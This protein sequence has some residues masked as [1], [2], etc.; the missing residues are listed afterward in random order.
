MKD[1]LLN[2]GADGEPCPEADDAIAPEALG[3]R[4]ASQAANEMSVLIKLARQRLPVIPIMT[5]LP[6]R[7]RLR[8]RHARADAR[9]CPSSSRKPDGGLE[10]PGKVAQERLGHSTNSVAAVSTSFRRPFPKKFSK[11]FLDCLHMYAMDRYGNLFQSAELANAALTQAATAVNQAA[12]AMAKYNHSS[13]NAGRD[14]MCAG[15]IGIQNGQLVWIDHNSGHNKPTRQNLVEPLRL[16]RDG[17]VDLSQA[18]VAAYT[19]TGQ[20]KIEIFTAQQFLANPD[21][22]PDV[23]TW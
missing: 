7:A 13:F 21:G 8:R 22:P 10:L 11:A 6:Q 17:R 15:L 3:L 20:Q 9:R 23:C 1:I 16:R 2:R 4:S 14:V 5:A 19:Y 18:K 12:A